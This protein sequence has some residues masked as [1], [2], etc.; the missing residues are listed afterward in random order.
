MIGTKVRKMPSGWA[1]R[2][3]ADWRL[4]T[5]ETPPGQIEFAM[6]PWLFSNEKV[7]ETLGWTPRYRTR[8]T[9]L[10][11]MRAQGRLE[12]D[13]GERVGSVAEDLDRREA[14]VSH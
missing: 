12:A 1:G 10:I 8:E 14:P 2:S 11:A 3:Q 7:K 9:F 5:S 4:R 13:R 6:N